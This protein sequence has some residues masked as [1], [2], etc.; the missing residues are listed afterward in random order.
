MKLFFID[1]IDQLGKSRD[2][3]L[4]LGQFGNPYELLTEFLIQIDGFEKKQNV[5]IIGT[6]NNLKL[7]DPAF[8][9]PGRFD[10]IF[11][12]ELPNLLQRIAL[13]KR[14]AQ[15]HLTKK[16][17]KDKQCSLISWNFFGCLTRNLSPAALTTVV[18]ESLLE[19]IRLNN[20]YHSFTTLK[21][22]F[23][24][25]VFSSIAYSRGSSK[26]LKQGLLSGQKNYNQALALLALQFETQTEAQQFLKSLQINNL[27][28]QQG[29]S[30]FGVSTL[31]STY[32]QLRNI[33]YVKLTELILKK[34][35]TQFFTNKLIKQLLQI[36]SMFFQIETLWI[37]PNK[38]FNQEKTV[39][40]YFCLISNQVF[41]IQN[42]LLDSKNLL[43]QKTNFLYFQN[44][45]FRA[46]AQTHVSFEFIYPSF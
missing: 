13:I 34:K 10:Q 37:N 4:G 15:S 19:I 32:C 41:N 2:K 12:L 20:K 30:H 3:T 21:N 1:E 38:Y 9:R 44:V 23:Y 24:R 22:A 45:V 17:D 8:I 39:E 29:K 14:L 18:N 43:S 26:I 11:Q 42:S 25:L 31:K 27:N 28:F 7:L 36:E 46:L 6:T 5:L 40:G 35:Y 16:S 33:F